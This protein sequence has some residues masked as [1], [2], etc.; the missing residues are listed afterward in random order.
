MSEM[1][2]AVANKLLKKYNEDLQRTYRDEDARSSYTEVQGIEPTVPD[3]DFAKTR[4]EVEALMSKI[5][6][7]KH[8]IN[9]FNT[10]MVLEKAGMT[11]D[12]ALVYMAMLTKEKSRL[13]GLLV[14]NK[15]TLK[16]GFGARSNVVEYVVAN[17]NVENVRNQYERV[18]Q[19]LTDLQ[20]ELDLVNSTVMFE[21]NV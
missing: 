10:T 17:Y 19:R 13:E 14:P 7:I 8:A 3:Y 16:T 1:T 15:K 6:N 9:V 21:V 20:V 5:R 4:S 11:I 18:N 2:S 12:E